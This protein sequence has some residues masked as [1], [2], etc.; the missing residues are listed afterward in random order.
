MVRVRRP[1][2]LKGQCAWSRPIQVVEVLGNYAYRLSDGQVWNAR[3]MRRYLEP[4]IAWDDA[5]SAPAAQPA[6]AA[7]GSQAA[8][9]P[10]PRRSAR[11]NRGVPPLRYPDEH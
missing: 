10:A 8:P 7:P 2:V 4:D 11:E 3:K 1:Q 5:A 6:A 9:V